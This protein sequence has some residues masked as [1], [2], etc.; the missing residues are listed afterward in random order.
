MTKIIIITLF[1]LL[2]CTPGDDQE[3][4]DYSTNQDQTVASTGSGNDVSN[5]GTEG[6]GNDG[7]NQGTEGVG[8]GISKHAT[9][10]TLVYP[11]ITDSLVIQFT[12]AN[13]EI[14]QLTQVYLTLKSLT[15]GAI[16]TILSKNKELANGVSMPSNGYDVVFALDNTYEI[17]SVSMTPLNNHYPIDFHLISNQQTVFRVKDIHSN[18]PPTFM[19][20]NSPTTIKI[21]NNN[22]D[23]ALTLSHTGE[24]I[25]KVYQCAHHSQYAI[26]GYTTSCSVRLNSIEINCGYYRDEAGCRSFMETKDF[27]HIYQN[28]IPY[29]N[30]IIEVIYEQT[31]I[32]NIICNSV[33]IDMGSGNNFD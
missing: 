15:T 20:N 16:T 4:V 5:L 18:I 30:S 25:P 10:E 26:Q 3:E 7:N 6:I 1:L 11:I 31:S 14:L 8:L 23:A 33:L 19:I 21:T 24:C 27:C 32:S 17:V 28:I 9:F 12:K 13:E 22:C 29:N 2:S